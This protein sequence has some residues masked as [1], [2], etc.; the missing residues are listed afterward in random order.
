MPAWDTIVFA[1]SIAV[2][3]ILVLGSAL[4]AADLDGA[5]GFDHD[6]DADADLDA[7][8]DVDV[9][10]D[11]DADADTDVHTDTHGSALHALGVGRVPLVIVITLLCFFFGGAGLIVEPFLH[12][13]FGPTLGG[14]ASLASASLLALPVTSRTCRL[15]AR[16]MPKHESYA[17][18]K[19]DLVGRTAHVIVSGHSGEVV[20]RVTDAGGAE[21]RVVALAS[22]ELRL[23]TGEPVY[24]VAYDAQRD[25][26]AIA[27]T[28][29]G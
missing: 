20:L 3:C 9:D 22:P 23:A 8:V 2:G 13:S 7:D 27:R 5:I 16:V 11:V 15:L 24:L 18:T 19:Q 6:V 25:R 12:A 21:Q 28:D 4:G 29:S 10:A 17:G 26:F 1:A 14:V